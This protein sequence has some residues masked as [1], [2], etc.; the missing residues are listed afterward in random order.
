MKLLALPS[1][2]WQHSKNMSWLV[3]LVLML[4][5]AIYAFLILELAKRSGSRNLNEFMVES[6]GKV[7][8]KI[9]MVLLFVKYAIMVASLTKG[10][11]F[12]V[13][14]NFYENFDWPVFMLPLIALIGFMAYK[15]IRNIARV[16]EIFYLPI[17]FGCLYVSLKTIKCIDPITYLPMFE[18]GILPLL[19]S[20]YNHLNW[21]SSSTFLL[22]LF[23][24]IDFKDEK[25][26]K[27]ILYSLSA[28][29]FVQLVYFV[30]YSLFGVTSPIHNFA[31]SDICQFS[32]NKTSTDQLVWLVVSLWVVAQALQL[33][34]RGYCMMRSLQLI[35]NTK[36]NIFALS[37]TTL[38][39]FALGYFGVKTINLEKVF[40]AEYTT[41]ITIIT[42]YV[43]PIILWIG[44]FANKKK[45][46]KVAENEKII[47]SNL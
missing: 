11:E 28:I 1:L 40:L 23:G 44:Y 42:Q 4:V 19:K 27:F 34:L 35:F 46:K 41:I 9:F 37:V 3:V 29:L 2:L 14:E 18:D 16:S 38:L 33:A 22:I 10:L 13:V 39:I 17:I 47:K 36:N 6:I 8:T 26:H 24:S 21:C 31:I 30:F 32:S 43:L 7:P 12:F 20:G 15:G 45:F 25:K 5:D